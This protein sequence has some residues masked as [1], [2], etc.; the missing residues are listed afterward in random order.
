MANVLLVEDDANL[1]RALGTLL[2]VEGHRV[3][4]AENGT[5]ALNAASVEAPDII[6]TDVMMPGM[7]G[8]ALVRRLRERRYLRI[9]P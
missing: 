2:V 8:I 1:L 6:V 5:E 3:R 7:D 9:S 4:R